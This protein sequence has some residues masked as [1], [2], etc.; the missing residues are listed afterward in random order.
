MNTDNDNTSIIDLLGL[1]I[2]DISIVPILSSIPTPTEDDNITLKSLMANPE[3]KSL[4]RPYIE[5]GHSVLVEVSETPFDPVPAQ[6]QNTQSLFTIPRE[7]GL[8]T[9]ARLTLKKT[10][11][12]RARSLFGSSAPRGTRVYKICV[13][14]YGIVVPTSSG[15]EDGEFG[16]EEETVTNQTDD[17]TESRR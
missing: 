14:D 4:M 5:S 11:R 7:D 16:E 6:R 10:M 1:S 8:T 12:D 2:F 9:N 17:Q 15:F 13:E 3:F